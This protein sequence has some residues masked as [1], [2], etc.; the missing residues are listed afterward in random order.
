MEV[1][2]F[3]QVCFESYIGVLGVGRHFP[4]DLSKSVD[5]MYVLFVVV[6]LVYKVDETVSYTHLDVYKRQVMYNIYYVFIMLMAIVCV[7]RRSLRG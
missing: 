2:S 4:V 1:C 5:P 6:V 3:P 7:V